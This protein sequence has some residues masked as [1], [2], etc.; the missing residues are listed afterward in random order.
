M[1][2]A[3]L[4]QHLNSIGKTAFVL[5]FAAFRRCAHSDNFA[6]C[7]RVL[8]KAGY[9]EN[10]RSTQCSKARAIFRA[11]KDKAALTICKD[12]PRMDNA[13]RKKAEALLRKHY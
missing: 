13:V 7:L 6:A 4:L 10:T 1:N 9:A 2:R 12:S 5:H 11:K 3:A 8:E